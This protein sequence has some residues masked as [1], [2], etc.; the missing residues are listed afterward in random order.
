M[1]TICGMVVSL[2]PIVTKPS[3]TTYDFIEFA[4]IGGKRVSLSNVVATTPAEVDLLEPCAIGE[5]DF[6]GDVSASLFCGLR[7]ADGPGRADLFG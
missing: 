6:K 3:G 2:G 7:R 5:F 1:F 4:R